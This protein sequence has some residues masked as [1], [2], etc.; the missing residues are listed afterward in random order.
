MQFMQI[1]G[2]GGKIKEN[3][4]F[5]SNFGLAIRTSDLGVVG[6]VSD[7]FDGPLVVQ[8]WCEVGVE[9]MGKWWLVV[10][11]WIEKCQKGERVS[12]ERQKKE[13]P[14]VGWVVVG[15]GGTGGVVVEPYGSGGGSR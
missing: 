8:G 9:V 14:A 11:W 3:S 4:I 6:G 2:V 15:G 7:D 1:M 12:A 13:M 5:P 10:V